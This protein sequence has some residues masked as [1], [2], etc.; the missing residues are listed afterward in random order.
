MYLYLNKWRKNVR[1]K[2]TDLQSLLRHCHNKEFPPRNTYT[3]LSLFLSIVTMPDRPSPFKR[4]KEWS[5]PAQLRGTD[6]RRRRTGDRALVQSVVNNPGLVPDGHSRILG[7][8]PVDPEL[9][10]SATTRVS[11]AKWQNE[12]ARVSSRSSIWSAWS[13]RQCGRTR[14]T[15]LLTRC[16]RGWCRRRGGPW[17]ITL[18]RITCT[19]TAIW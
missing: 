3:F 16:T 11:L 10:L 14:W 9:N 17:T 2:Q 8:D 12:A 13:C 6:S 4:F 15:S 1:L 5:N 18:R 7:V 19:R